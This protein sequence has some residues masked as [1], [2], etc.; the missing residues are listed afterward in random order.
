MPTFDPDRGFTLTRTF[1]A[2]RAKVWR[3]L[4]E[5]ELFARWFGAEADV[6][7][8]SWDLRSGGDWTAVMTYEGTEIPWAGRFVE[9]DA[10]NR[11]AIRIT[12]EGE[13]KDTDDV[14]T[15]VLTDAG[16]QT[17]LEFRQAGGGLTDEQYREAE[18]G[19]ESFLDA[20]ARVIATL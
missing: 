7:V 11:I 12:D 5:P 10:P 17:T 8:T 15:M 18:K 9:V 16:D 19:T 4:S 6:T 1:D 20:M 3:A 2:P 13:V 14:L